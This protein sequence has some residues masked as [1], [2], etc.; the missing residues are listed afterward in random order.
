MPLSIF[1]GVRSILCIAA[2]GIS[3]LLSPRLY[4]ADTGLRDSLQ[5]LVR[6]FHG[7]AGI[8]VRHLRT[9]ETVAI[10]ADSLFPTASMIKVTI[11]CTLFDRMQRRELA[12][13]SVLVYRDSQR[14]AGVDILGSFKDSAKIPVSE[15]A[16]LMITMSDN[17]ASR[18]LQELAGGGTAINDWL[19]RNGFHALRINS[20]TPGRE[21]ERDRWG[22]GVTS[23]REMAGLL[24]KIRRM[25]LFDSAACIELYRVLGRT[26]WDAE[27][28]SQIPPWVR[29]ASKQ[30]SLD[31]S[32]SEVFL[33]NA[34]SGDYVCCVA[35][36]NQADDRWVPDN[37]GYLFVRAVSRLLWR[38]FEPGAAWNSSLPA[39]RW[40]K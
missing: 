14:V 2:A 28:L 38:H 36:R 26:W 4:G 24:V 21:R 39:G 18:W 10:N 30:G 16:M 9:G 29:V 12:Y 27:A 33:V 22:W 35:T 11:L 23:P 3:L 34:P 8:Y 31:S 25:Q 40:W 1:C 6:S 5:E 13:D 20:R 19:E 32:K 37:E 17:T 15:L 7:D